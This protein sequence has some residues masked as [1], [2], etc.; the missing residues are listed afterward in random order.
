MPEKIPESRCLLNKRSSVSRVRIIVIV[1]GSLLETDSAPSTPPFQRYKYLSSPSVFQIFP[2]SFHITS[3]I[4]LLPEISVQPVQSAQ[5][6]FNSSHLRYVHLYPPWS[7]LPN[8]FSLFL[9]L[10]S[11]STTSPPTSSS[12]FPPYLYP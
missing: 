10:A 4:N 11:T 8:S 3:N 2:S 7:S 6:N 1:S 12:S 5:L 9:P